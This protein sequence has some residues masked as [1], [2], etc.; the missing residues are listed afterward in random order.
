M[1]C[2]FHLPRGVKQ[3]CIWRDKNL[4]DIAFTDIR[5]CDVPINF[6]YVTK[7]YRVVLFFFSLS[8]FFPSSPPLKRTSIRSH[9]RKRMFQRRFLFI[10][11]VI[12]SRTKDA[13]AGHLPGIFTHIYMYLRIEKCSVATVS[14]RILL[15]PAFHDAKYVSLFHPRE[16]KGSR[17]KI[18]KKCAILRCSIV[19][20][21]Y[22]AIFTP[23]ISS[24]EYRSN[25]VT[26]SR[27]TKDTKH[28]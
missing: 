2:S 10:P 27:N 26:G 16:R 8:F 23:S 28:P 5:R 1:H 18:G 21:N 12:Q 22:M 3:P 17:V 13:H 19:T 6:N 24:V 20:S 25:M 11:H 7:I 4:R 15:S 9:N 14:T